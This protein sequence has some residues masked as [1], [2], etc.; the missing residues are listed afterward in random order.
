MSVRNFLSA[1]V[2]LY[3]TVQYS[4]VT[5]ST[6]PKSIENCTYMYITFN[7][8]LLYICI[9]TLSYI[10]LKIISCGIRYMYITLGSITAPVSIGSKLLLA[11]GFSVQC[12]SLYIHCNFKIHGAPLQ[13]HLQVKITRSYRPR[14]C[15]CMYK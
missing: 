2:H 1:N 13:T 4:N 11:D 6:A 15:T 14:R 5:C 9:L 8:T 10:D 3:H 12:K 7:V